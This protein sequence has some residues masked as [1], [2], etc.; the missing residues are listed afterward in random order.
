MK[1]KCLRFECE[2]CTKLASIQLFYNKSGEV[3]YARAR[4][5]SGQLNGKPQ[6]EYHQQSLDYIQRKLS[7]M[8]TGNAEIGHIGQDI[9]D[10]LL[11]QEL[12]SNL[13]SMAGGDGIEPSFEPS[14]R[15]GVE[16]CTPSFWVKEA[17]PRSHRGACARPNI[18]RSRY[19]IYL[20]KLPLWL[21]TLCSPYL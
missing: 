19:N 8:P 14:G 10:D 13:R 16:D 1:I 6:F 15:N 21:V 17:K 5:Y 18:E 12:S 20:K 2:I 3:K 9:N 4:H 7:E 11:K